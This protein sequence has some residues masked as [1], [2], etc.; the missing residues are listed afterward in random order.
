MDHG[1]DNIRQWNLLVGKYIE[2]HLNKNIAFNLKFNSLTTLYFLFYNVYRY[3][4]SQYP[5]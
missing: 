4:K 5:S 3:I 2:K 1:I